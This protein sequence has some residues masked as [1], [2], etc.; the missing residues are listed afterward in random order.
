MYTVSPDTALVAA[1]RNKYWRE[2]DAELVLSAWAD[3]GQSLSAFGRQYSISVSRLRRWK[4]RLADKPLPLFHS[5]EVINGPR[6]DASNDLELV[7]RNG[8]RVVVRAGFDEET[9]ERLAQLVESWP[10]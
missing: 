6:M 8:R 7:L 3:S 10:C 1:A 9:L 2:R 5:V 4:R